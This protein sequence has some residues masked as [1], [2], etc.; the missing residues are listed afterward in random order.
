MTQQP[1]PLV[2][3]SALLPRKIKRVRQRKR[4]PLLGL[5]KMRRQQGLARQIYRTGQAIQCDQQGYSKAESHVLRL[6]MR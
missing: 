2:P 3:E 1:R 5:R 6:Y 4:Y